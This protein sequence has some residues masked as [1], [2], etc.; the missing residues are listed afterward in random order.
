MWKIFMKSSVSSSRSMDNKTIGTDIVSVNR[1]QKLAEDYG[2]R[3]YQHLFTNEEV[4]WCNERPSP[5]IHLAG[6]FAAKEAV[7]KALLSQGE[8]NI[9]PLNAIEIR[10]N[11]D[12]PPKVHF[13]TELSKTYT[14]EV[15]I[16]HT[17]E[18]AIAVALASHS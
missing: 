16:S 2:H 12:N 14:V 18:Y 1:I 8:K 3:F 6:R 4:K 9:L 13:H 15:S 7:K 11:P 17:D 5:F 10:R